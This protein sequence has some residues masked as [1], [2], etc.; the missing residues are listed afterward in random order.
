MWTATYTISQILTFI[1]YIF[2][3]L[4]YIERSRKQILI[5]SLFVHV[6]QGISFYLLNGYTGIAVNIFYMIRDLFFLYDPRD[7]NSKKIEKKDYVVLIIFMSIII[8]FAFLSYDGFLSL[9]SV[10]A[11]IT[12]TIAVWQRDTK[13]FRF[14]G[15]VSSVLW[16][17]YHISLHSIVAIVLESCLLIVTIVEYIREILRKNKNNKSE[18]Y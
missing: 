14:L 15:I 6:I 12:S 2:L 5:T 4:T 3:I 16:L 1:V 10:F 17:I 9:F 11:A 7:V 13:I 8:I 18:Y